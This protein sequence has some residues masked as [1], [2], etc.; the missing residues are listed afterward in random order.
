MK[1][2]SLLKTSVASLVLASTA[3]LA[4]PSAQ[5]EHTR[6]TNPNVIGVELLGQGVLYSIF[7]DRVLNDDL[8]AGFGY[9][10]APTETAAGGNTGVSAAFIPVHVNYYFTR[11][12]GS[13]YGT[14]GVTIVTNP[15]E[16]AGTQSKLSISELRY[17][18]SPILPVVGIGYENRGD[19]GFLFRGTAY[20]IFA[21]TI[22]PWIG[23]SFGYAF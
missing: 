14:G 5:A 11:D 23:F 16:I 6:V 1:I 12:Q 7:Y 8:V 10:V 3:G 21:D 19:M 22:S 13:F 9:G 4:A 2:K 15:D 17:S 18:D 20:A